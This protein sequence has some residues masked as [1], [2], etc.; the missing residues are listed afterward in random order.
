MATCIGPDCDRDARAEGLCL[1]HYR[2]ALR[3]RERGESV[4]LTP[5]RGFGSPLVSRQVRLPRSV[6]EALEAAARE[7]PKGTASGVA[8]EVLEAWAAERA[9]KRRKRR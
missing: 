5:L 2:Q 7:R 9:P 4:V 8:R 1:S 3:C 6:D